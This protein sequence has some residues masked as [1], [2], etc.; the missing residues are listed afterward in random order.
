VVRGAKREGHSIEGEEK[1][2]E[3]GMGLP[4]QRLAKSPNSLRNDIHGRAVALM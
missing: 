2:E 4:T 1:S 3:L